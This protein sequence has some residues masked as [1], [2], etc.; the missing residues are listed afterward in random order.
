MGRTFAVLCESDKREYDVCLL[1]G[2][3]RFR[4]VDHHADDL[5]I[6]SDQP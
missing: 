5:R 4:W 6:Q 2:Y 1:L 3:A